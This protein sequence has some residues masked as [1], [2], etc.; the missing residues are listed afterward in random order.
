VESK[1]NFSR[2]TIEQLGFIKDVNSL[3][4]LSGTYSDLVLQNESYFHTVDAQVTLF[5]LPTLAPPTA[6]AKTK[7]AFSFAIHTAVQHL[8]TSASTERLAEGDFSKTTS[9]PT[10]VSQ[11]VVGCRRKIVVYTWTDGE[12][13]EPKVSSSLLA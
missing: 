13:Q 8:S 1:K 4:V 11:L 2:R 7:T 12:A 10:L 3:V 5:P 9:I 6:L